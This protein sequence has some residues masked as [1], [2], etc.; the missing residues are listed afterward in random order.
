MKAH[1]LADLVKERRLGI[2]DEKGFGRVCRLGHFQNGSFLTLK[3]FLNNKKQQNK[4]N[5]SIWNIPAFP[6]SDITVGPRDHDNISEQALFRGDDDSGLHRP[7]F[8]AVQLGFDWPEYGPVPRLARFSPPRLFRMDDRELP[9]G[10]VDRGRPGFHFGHLG[11]IEDAAAPNRS[12][13]SR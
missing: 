2:G 1:D 13:E 9:S 7:A 11:F 12:N 3:M 6:T 8:C 5:S 10:W 4:I